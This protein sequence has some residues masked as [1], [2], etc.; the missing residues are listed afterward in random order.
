MQESNN[1]EIKNWEE[2]GVTNYNKLINTKEIK[3]EVGELKKPIGWSIIFKLI[4]VALIIPL[5]LLSI[6]FQ[7]TTITTVG[8]I[9]ESIIQLVAILLNEN[10]LFRVKAIKNAKKV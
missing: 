5:L 1:H 3:A 6:N 7:I 8:I 2:H 10:F 9:N 4:K